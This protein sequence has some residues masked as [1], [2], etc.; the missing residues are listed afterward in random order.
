MF[1]NTYFEEHLCAIASVTLIG[2][3]YIYFNVRTK[4]VKNKECIDFDFEWKMQSHFSYNF[5]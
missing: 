3:T 2:K 5:C 4:T 1:K